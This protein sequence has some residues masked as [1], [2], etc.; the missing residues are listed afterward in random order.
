MESMLPV[1]L[2][3]DDNDDHDHFLG[4]HQFKLVMAATYILNNMLENMKKLAVITKEI[5]IPNSN[6]HFIKKKSTKKRIS[7][8]FSELMQSV[9]N[10]YESY[11]RFYYIRYF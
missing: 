1:H 10:K 8:L 4:L 6:I 5:E 9:E 2:D 11:K 3:D 7:R